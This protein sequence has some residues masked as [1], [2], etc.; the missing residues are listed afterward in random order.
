MDFFHRERYEMY[1]M[2]AATEIAHNVWLGPTPDPNI[3]GPPENQPDRPEFDLMISCS[4]GVDM[5]RGVHLKMAERQLDQKDSSP[6][7]AKEVTVDELEFPAS[8]AILPPTC[9]N[10][11]VS[12]LL[13]TCRF[14]YNQANRRSLK[15][16]RDSKF[17][18]G[19][20]RPFSSCR[21]DVDDAEGDRAMASSSD[22]ISRDSQQ[23]GRQILIHCYDGYTESSLLALAYYMFA[24]GVRVHDAWLQ[25]H[26][27][28]GRN[29]FAYPSD[30][31]LLR[32]VEHLILLASPACQTNSTDSAAPSPCASPSIS[33]T[34]SP[35]FTPDEPPFT[36][37][38]AITVNERASRRLPSVPEKLSLIASYTSSPEPC[39]LDKMDGS[40]PSRILPYMYLGNLAHANNPSLLRALGIG[41][42][43]SVGENLNW[44]RMASSPDQD[45]PDDDEQDP[46]TDT[47]EFTGWTRSN[48]RFVDG[49]QDNGVDPLMEE[50]VKCLDFIEAGRKAGIATIV[51]C[52]VGVSRSATIC[53][54]HVMAALDLSFPRA[55]CFVRAR[56]LNVIIQPHLRFVYELLQWEEFLAG[57]R[58]K[59]QLQG[60]DAEHD[61]DGDVV[62]EEETTAMP[63]PLRELE[64]ASVAREIAAMN[65]PYARQ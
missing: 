16:R 23:R 15:R 53:I 65:K 12:R 26:L 10:T 2:S 18:A 6:D 56:R 50:L 39:W 22:D 63:R 59:R 40:L 20:D 31:Q 57:N 4:D 19:R 32:V 64:W 1:S 36:I 34:A 17:S 9:G 5:P 52:R 48:L 58:H 25:L 61:E 38:E 43:L 11:D 44:H 62:A 30:V 24:H 33:D 8:G 27:E 42:V 28:R 29:F 54:A 55:Y 37:P 14:I 41:Q 45:S 3:D 49:V 60:E 47:A 46:D 35:G 21:S 13:D 51:H 7:G